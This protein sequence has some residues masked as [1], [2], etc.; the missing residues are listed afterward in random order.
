[1]IYF[2]RHGQTEYNI[3]GR[4]QGQSDVPLN[5]EGKRQA[6]EVAEKL[7]NHHFDIIYCSPLI[8]AK[9]T[10]DEINKFHNL[11]LNFENRLME[12]YAGERQGLFYRDLTDEEKALWRTNPERWGA[13]TRKEFYD[14]CV[15]FY[16]EIENSDKDILLVSHGGVWRN[17]MRYFDNENT[18]FSI[19]QKYEIG[20]CGIDILDNYK[21][22]KK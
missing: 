3:T 15:S 13:E 8:R 22:E 6:K 1:M 2:V 17:L 7:K 14:R 19:D 5:E 18:D 4:T 10:A 20:N 16:K 9:H 11:P 21:K 12:R